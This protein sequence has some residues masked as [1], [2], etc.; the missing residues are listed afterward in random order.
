MAV[1]LADSNWY[2]VFFAR[3]VKGCLT[4]SAA[5]SSCST[6]R[7][8]A[9]AGLVFAVVSGN[10]ASFAFSL[11]GQSVVVFCF[12]ADVKEP[13]CDFWNVTKISILPTDLR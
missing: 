1:R 12:F 5:I 2:G 9:F 11:T 4:L 6:L 3:N 10:P 8:G 7:D 13:S